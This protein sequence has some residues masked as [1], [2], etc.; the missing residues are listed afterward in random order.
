MKELQPVTPQTDLVQQFLG[1]LDLFFSPQISLQEM[2]GAR[3]SPA[4]E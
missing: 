2:T 4:D 1:I 3:L